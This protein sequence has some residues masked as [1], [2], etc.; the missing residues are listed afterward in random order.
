M[1]GRLLSWPDWPEFSPAKAEPGDDLVGYKK[2]I[3]DKYGKNNI[4]ESWLKVCKALGSVTDRIA[5]QGT[6]AI[7]DIQFEEVSTL[8]PEKKQA[9]KDAGCFVVRGVFS[10][11]QTDKWFKELKD[12]VAAN[13]ASIEGMSSSAEPFEAID[14][15]TSL[16]RDRLAEG[17]PVHFKPLLFSNANGCTI[18][19]KPAETE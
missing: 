1:P 9:L 16:T 12:Y 17:D 18:A 15:V 14:L 4:I 7:P 8:A 13:R 6:S 10:R 2:A 11:E 5:E 19:P 3:V